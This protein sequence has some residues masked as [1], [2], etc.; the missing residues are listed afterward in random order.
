MNLVQK[1]SEFKM[2][3]QKFSNFIYKLY[4]EMFSEYLKKMCKP[5]IH[6][7]YNNNNKKSQAISWAG[8]GTNFP[9]VKFVLILVLIGFSL[10]SFLKRILSVK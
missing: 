3:P 1:W 9:V 10:S 5:A 4:V 7:L 2:F 6:I 8:P